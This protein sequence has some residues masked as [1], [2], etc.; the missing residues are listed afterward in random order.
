VFGANVLSP[1]NLV[2]S[3]WANYAGNPGNTIYYATPSFGG[4]SGAFS[5]TLKEANIGAINDFHVKYEGGPLTAAL[6]YQDNKPGAAKFTTVNA[7]YDLGVAKLLATV[8]RA[9]NAVAAD[10]S[11]YALGADVP[12]GGSMVLSVGYGSSKTKGASAAKSVSAAV[13]YVMSK[14]TTVYA[15]FAD[16]NAAAVA[17][18]GTPDSRFG[19]GVKHAF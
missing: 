7:T 19:V 8:A 13:A 12:L 1:L 3:S 11:E 4:I 15:G 9:N 2:F 14:R 5:H 6:A 18:R 16:G 17:G 10:V